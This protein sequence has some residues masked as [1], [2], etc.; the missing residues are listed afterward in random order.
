VGCGVR[1]GKLADEISPTQPFV[2]QIRIHGYGR[3]ARLRD[4]DC[5][6]NRYFCPGDPAAGRAWREALRAFGVDGSSRY[7]DPGF[8]DA[9]NG[10]FRLKEGAAALT[11]P[12]V[13]RK[14]IRSWGS[15]GMPSTS[16]SSFW[17]RVSP[18]AGR[19]S[20]TE[21]GPEGVGALAKLA[22]FTAKCNP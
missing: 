19:R 9:E 5:D 12:L 10:D 4:T 6:Q 20:R 21:P 2:G 11:L 1:W 7:D 14:A 8:V 18:Y 22:G 15:A 17:L 16:R 13:A 3:N